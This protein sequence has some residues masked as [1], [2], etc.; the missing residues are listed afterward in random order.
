MRLLLDTHLLI[1]W[2]TDDPKMSE[3]CRGLLAD[4]R[5]EVFF[6]SISIWEVAIKHAKGL[7]LLAPELLNDSARKSGLRPL[8]FKPQHAQ[9]VSKLPDHHQDPFDRALI[10]QA[11]TEP[12]TL[13]SRD[14]WFSSYP[15]S[16]RAV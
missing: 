9:Q 16:L 11:I 3:E 6:S 12:L 5:N 14:R 13:V 15:V 7:L 4:E 2:A 1:W 8:S 10:A